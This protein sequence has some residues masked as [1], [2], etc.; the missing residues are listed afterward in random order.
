[1][2]ASGASELRRDRPDDSDR[3][4][5]VTTVLLGLAATAAVVMLLLGLG[6]PVLLDGG[7]ALVIASCLL[8]GVANA[9]RIRSGGVPLEAERPLDV[10]AAQ[11]ELAVPVEVEVEIDGPAEV[12]ASPPAV[13]ASVSDRSSPASDGAPPGVAAT[14]RA[15]RRTPSPRAALAAY[16]S[17]IGRVGLV[18]VGIDLIIQLTSAPP[19]E[20][21]QAIASAVLCVLSAAAAALGARYLGQV[22]AAQFPEA[23][24]LSRG[25]RVL[26]WL[27]VAVTA[28]I[29]TTWAGQRVATWFLHVAILAPIVAACVE[30]LRPA[31]ASE[32]F[33]IGIG[34]FSVLGSRRNVIASLLDAGQRQLGVDLRSTWALTVIRR[35]VQ[36]LVLGLVLIGWLS[37]GLTIIGTGEAGLIE[38]FGVSLD[39]AT[40]EPGIHVHWPWPVDRVARIAVARVRS[41]ERAGLG[42]VA[43]VD[44][45]Q[46]VLGRKALLVELGILGSSEQDSDASQVWVAYAGRCLGH[47]VLLDQPRGEAREA[48]DAMRALGIDRLILLTGDRAAAAREV[49]DALG[50]DE[51]IAEVL[52]AQKLE[53]VRAQQAAGRTVMMVGDGVNDAL[54]LGGADVGVAIGA[55]LNEVALGGADVALL[56]AEL[57]RL[58]RLVQLADATRRAL[59]QNV[60]LAFGISVLLIALAAWGILDP[61]TGALTQSV[62]V[63]AVVANSARILRLSHVPSAMEH[64]RAL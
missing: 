56:G 41:H 57:G 33:E 46:A 51:V 55:E 62:G 45:Q 40:L 21:A 18:V 11:V 39:G 36:P 8:R 27:L 3:Y 49:G 42:V 52:P 35:Y 61:V 47:L 58:P 54:A 13:A 17:T 63:L 48:L 14:P 5:H 10:R 2:T 23:P 29:G 59:G 64:E 7:I 32:V 50:V 37:S 30:L 38:R 9:Q 16:R 24:A 25:A 34:V 44:G 19:I 1:M 20:P 26:V 4:R 43:T 15:P 12:T 31:V 53:V 22:D 28:A 6:E 60:W